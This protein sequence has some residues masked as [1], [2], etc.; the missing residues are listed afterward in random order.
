MAPTARPVSH[1]SF[2]TTSGSQ[3]VPRSFH[4]QFRLVVGVGVVAG[5]R[6]GVSA[7][8]GSI[9]TPIRLW[10]QP[11]QLRHLRQRVFG[12]IGIGRSAG[13][14]PVA[15]TVGR[16]TSRDS[17]STAS[18]RRRVPRP[19]DFENTA[20]LTTSGWFDHCTRTMYTRAPSNPTFPPPGSSIRNVEVGAPGVRGA[21]Q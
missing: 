21:S 8:S 10:G 3:C 7:R 17:C 2:V 12:C 15:S 4:S 13:S 1:L 16:A 6:S 20:S 9:R 19:L 14:L 5:E 11:S 18:R